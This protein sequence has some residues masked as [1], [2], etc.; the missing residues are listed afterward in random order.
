[1]NH[2]LAI[3]SAIFLFIAMGFVFYLLRLNRQAK[4]EQSE[5]DPNKLRP[6]IDD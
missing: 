1:M 5:I 2:I 4:K 3:G 6:W